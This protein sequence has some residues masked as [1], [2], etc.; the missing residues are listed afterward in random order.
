MMP[1]CAAAR[2]RKVRYIDHREQREH[3]A[4][5]AL[6]RKT[7][8]VLVGDIVRELY[9]DTRPDRLW[10]ATDNVEK[11]FRKFAG[12][13]AARLCCMTSGSEG[14]LA[15]FEPRAHASLAHPAMSRS[16]LDL[17]FVAPMQSAWCFGRARRCS[18]S[19]HAR[20]A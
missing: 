14:R 12:D 13:G 1:P 7:R 4:W 2:V 5:E 8:P 18:F 9:P 6:Q 17:W 3:Q 15:Y 11:L 16:A 20:F 10:M 19:R